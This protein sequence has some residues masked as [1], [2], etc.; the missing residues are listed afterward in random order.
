MMIERIIVIACYKHQYLTFS[1]GTHISYNKIW[2]KI[3]Y[4]HRKTAVPQINW[5]HI[6][7]KD[8]YQCLKVLRISSH[9]TSNALC[10]WMHIVRVCVCVC[11]Q[12]LRICACR[13]LM[14]PALI[15]F[16]EQTRKL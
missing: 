7:H 4:D 12:T 16:Y 8:P 9:W 15:I 11:I 1:K 14:P 2:L 13:S 5:K 3:N 10:Q 6:I